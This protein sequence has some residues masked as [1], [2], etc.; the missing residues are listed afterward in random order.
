MAPVTGS[1]STRRASFSSVAPEAVARPVGGSAGPAES[2][3]VVRLRPAIPRTAT[4]SEPS[5]RRWLG[6]ARPRASLTRSPAAER[7][8]ES[9]TRASRARAI[10]F[11]TSTDVLVREPRAGAAAV[12]WACDNASSKICRDRRSASSAKARLYSHW[13][14]TSGRSGSE[15][16]AAAPQVCSCHRSICRHA[17]S[18]RSRGSPGGSRISHSASLCTSRLAA[19]R[20]RISSPALESAPSSQYG[21]RSPRFSGRLAP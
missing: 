1:S 14:T 15:M 13:A 16:L 8:A 5:A 4:A 2:L 21:V 18:A 19:A 3:R 11:T 6:R 17:S 9:V 10:V 12:A 20:A 7:S